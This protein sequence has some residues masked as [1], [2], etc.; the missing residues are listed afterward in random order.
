[1]KKKVLFFV[2]A[3]VASALLVPNVHAEGGI[4]KIG[5]VEYATLQ[6]A[7]NAATSGETVTLGADT[8]ENITIAADKNITLDLGTYTL[9]NAS[10]HTIVNN[11]KLTITGNGTVD[12]VTNGKGALVNKGTVTILSGTFT[13]SHEAGVQGSNGGNSWYVIDNNGSTATLT[14]KGGKV[15]NTSGYSSLIRNFEATLIVEDGIFENNFIVLK[16]DDNGV[17]EVSGGTISTKAAG[18]SAVQNWGEFNLTGGTLNAVENSAAIYTLSWDDGYNA[19]ITTVTDGTING[20]IL[21]SEDTNYSPTISPRVLINGGIVNG[22]IEATNEGQVEITDGVITGV[23]IADSS[24]TVTTTGGTYAVEPSADDIP[25]GYKVFE[26]E[27]G[28]FTVAV[29]VLVTFSSEDYEETVEV[30]F[31]ASLTDDEIQYLLEMLAAEL[32]GTNVSFDGFYAD[33]DFTTEFDF[34]EPFEQDVTVYLKLTETAQREED[35]FNPETSDIN[36]IIILGVLLIGGTGLAFTLK[37]R[38]FN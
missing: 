11:G 15:I 2:M 20:D 34:T 8:T 14:F 5:D 37:N 30:P 35:K 25:D 19:P 29:P 17:L 26:N 9:T 28:T 21:V 31:G 10:S 1:M 4:A 3:F 6:E 13:R 38:K 18:G 23:V 32:E 16:N 22:D 36:L 12:N 24:A 27:D 7:V 33:E